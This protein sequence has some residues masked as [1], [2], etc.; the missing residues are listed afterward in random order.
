MIS[1]FS[2]VTLPEDTN[3]GRKKEEKRSTQQLLF[4]F[5]NVSKINSSKVA[6]IEEH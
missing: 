1:K 2:L 5:W 4:Y 3:H 6:F